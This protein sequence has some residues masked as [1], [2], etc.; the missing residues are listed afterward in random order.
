M[1]VNRWE[2]ERLSPIG[3]LVFLLADVK[4]QEKKSSPEGA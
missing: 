4:E 1:L 3:L 2:M